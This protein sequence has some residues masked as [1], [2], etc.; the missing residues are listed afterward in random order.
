[1]MEHLPVLCE[2]LGSFS[3]KERR[4]DSEGLGEVMGR[5][6]YIP[7]FHVRD[8]EKKAEA[9]SLVKTDLSC[10]RRCSFSATCLPTLLHV[11]PHTCSNTR[12]VGDSPHTQHLCALRIRDLFSALSGSL[13]LVYCLRLTDEEIWPSPW[14]WQLGGSNKNG[15]T[16]KPCFLL[17]STGSGRHPGSSTVRR[18]Q[19]FKLSMVS[20]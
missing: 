7:E 5:N 4:N 18:F 8:L 3:T 12:A 19:T 13:R 17:C 1:M 14:K 2:A 6:A 20:N 16:S 10:R 9:Q 15:P 11:H